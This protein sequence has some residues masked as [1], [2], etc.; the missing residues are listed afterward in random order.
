MAPSST[1]TPLQLVI[2]VLPTGTSVISIDSSVLPLVVNADTN[3]TRVEVG[4]YNTSYAIDTFSLVGANN[5]FAQSIPLAPSVL[6]TN[7]TIIGRNYDPAS[8]WEPGTNYSMSERFADPNGNVEVVVQSTGSGTSSSTGSV[9]TATSVV[10]NVLT[11][12]CS[13]TF[14]VG[15]PVVLTGTAEAALNG[16]TVLVAALITSGGNQIGFTATLVANN[17]TNSADT[18]SAVPQPRWSR[19]SPTVG[20]SVSISGN[21]L[22]VNCANS[23]S[24]G[25]SVYL[26]GFVNASFLNGQVVTVSFA[27]PTEFTAPITQANYAAASDS[28]TVQAATLDN[29]LV[30][31]NI[32]SQAVTPTIR[33]SLLF[34]QSNLSV[35]IAPPSGISAL[36]DQSNCTLQWVTPDYPGFIGV[37]VQI[38]TDSAGVNP[39]F[40]Q[41]GDLVTA[42]SSS[43]ETVITSSSNTS[44]NVP[45]AIISNVVL[46]NNLATITARNSFVPGMVVNVE[47]LVNATFLNG[48]SLTILAATPSG[49]TSLFTAENYGNS[50]TA[51]QV[52]GNIL[53]VTA[54][55]SYTIGQQ[56]VISGTAEPFLNGQVLVV[57][58]ASPFYFT[59]AFT[60]A[61]YSNPSDIGFASIGD[62]GI[63]TSVISTSTTS[64]ANTSMLT[65]YSTVDIPFSTI[66][67]TTFYAMFSTVIQDPTTNIVYES[68]ENGPLLCGYVNLQVA[69]PTD[70]PVL[71]RKED[72]AGRLIAQINKQLPNLDLSP[73]SEIRDIFID[74]FSIEAANMSVREWF[75][76]V[77][78]SISAISQVDNASGNGLSDPFQSSPYK[79]QIARAYGLSPQNT[80]NLINEQFDLLGEGAG[81]TRLGSEQATVVLTFYTYQQ[82][83]SS[84]TIP[85]GATVS[86]VPDSATSALVFT[87]Q[88][89]GTINIANLASFFNSNAGWWGVSVPAQCTQPGSVGNVGAGTIRQTV[90]G[91]PSGIN[92]TNL[93]GAQFGQDQESNSAFAARIQA[94]KFTGN[95]SSS[96]NGYLVTALSTPG[97]ISAQVVAAGD[98]YMLRDWD[99]TRLKHV[100]GA[101]DIY[102]RGTTFSQQDEFVPFS[103]ANNGVY[104]TT[105][106]YSTLAYIGSNTFQIANYNTLAFPPYD[107]VE[108]FVSR[109]SNSFYLSLDRAQFNVTTGQIILNN[110]DIAYQY[111][112]NSVTQAKVPLLLNGVPATNQAALAALSGASTGTYSFALFM[113]LASPFLHVPALQPVLQVYSVTG[114]A[115]ESGVLPSSDVTL[116]HTSD[117]LLYGGSNDAGDIVQVLLTSAPTQSTVT[118]GPLTAPTLIDIGMNQPLGPN[119]VP[120]NVLSVRSLDLSTLYQFGTDYSIVAYGPYRE[121]GI[122]PLTSSVTLTQLQIV[123]NVLTVT[124]PNDFGVG[125][126][127]Q[128]SGIVDPTFAS[129]LNGQTVVIGTASPTQFTATFHFA[130]TGPTLT[131]GVVTG[132]AIQAGQ[133]VIVSYNEYVLYERL[134]FVSGESQVLSG[135]LP[136]TLDNDG[137]V[138]N[139]WLP[140][141]YSTGVFNSSQANTS[142]LPAVPP[143]SFN[144]LALILDGWNGNFGNDGGL[145]V[146]GSATFDPSGLVGNQIPY[147]SRY[148][149]VVYY[150]GVSNVVMKENIDFTLTVDPVSGSA[151]LARILTGRIPDG[152]TVSVSYFVTETFT[153][154]TQYPTFVEL[155][156]N[157]IAQTKSAAADV[158]IKAEIANDVDITM[159]VT[160]D[161][162]ANAATVDPVIRTA[163][164]VVLDNSSTTLYQSELVSQVQAI[165][166]VQ[167]VEL[168]LIKC[169][170]SNGSYDIGIVIPTGTVWTQTNTSNNAWI[171]TNSVLPD[172]TIPTGGEPTAI[173]DLLYQGQVFRRATSLLDFQTN[174]PAVP[175]LAVAPGV[176]NASPGS[177]YIY[178]TDDPVNS[179]KVAL[180]IPLDVPTPAQL[181]FFVTYQVFNEGGAKD[182]T[183]SPTEYL[184]PGTITINYVSNPTS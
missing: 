67:A 132:S 143:F 28:G 103:Y 71:Q 134:S 178:G 116:I 137:F 23:F 142:N 88:G 156:A 135:T 32:G 56:V 155:L 133:Q 125:A 159:T 42:I 19:L 43:A 149:K 40:T 154:S 81:L 54:T 27:D 129:I 3:T 174:S 144:P 101:V 146:V 176:V 107:G 164:N 52:S 128:L 114:S 157:T 165:T 75:A 9:I 59:A 15:Q 2:P 20:T 170:K 175:H 82:P 139:T 58:T 50:I 138:Q 6:E 120:L 69:N 57:A 182:V 55:N 33:F 36:K 100:F 173:V 34:A 70:F 21:L 118:I 87:T 183:V 35:A 45:T 68:V 184:A 72:I 93:V 65:N 130:N 79:Q 166:G 168:P 111:V 169:A 37:R 181:S 131:S 46:A 74:P 110:G 14:A 112:G 151:T 31:A 30:W 8:M 152:G 83:T 16:Q 96:A 53:T 162:N 38:S 39:P 179:G 60:H 86:T 91:V 161:A 113:R 99:P 84:I 76:R 140:Q 29:Q 44:V 80:Q 172:S 105:N 126:T 167:S 94:R 147:A 122:Q 62:N 124:V 127:V 49:F 177:F 95:D 12:T 98:L 1:L 5:Q 171:S 61:N 26:T 153:V 160:L 180:T 24:T 13:N 104:G 148:I 145:D 150:N 141:S 47:S 117:F 102:A 121:Y 77:S 4:I 22:T 119:G 89:Q 109:S 136:T 97:V 64:T 108:L 158:L 85:E 106:T 115:T 11:V 25:Q 18:G 90:S 78:T 51:T 66:N 63:A 163:I 10:G 41:Y 7:V 48:E 123:N 17:Y 92:V 73:R